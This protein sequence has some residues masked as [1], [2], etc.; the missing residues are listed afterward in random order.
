MSIEVYLSCSKSY[1]GPLVRTFLTCYVYVELGFSPIQPRP[2][3]NR[4]QGKLTLFCVMG[5]RSQLKQFLMML[6]CNYNS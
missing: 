4:L 2:A 3:V 6:Y 5:G 1:L